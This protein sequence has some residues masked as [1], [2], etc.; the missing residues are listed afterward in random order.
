MEKNPE[1]LQG[2]ILKVAYEL[3]DRLGKR[4]CL[5]KGR[6]ERLRPECYHAH[7]I[8]FLT[9]EK[10][11]KMMYKIGLGILAVLLSGMLYQQVATAID[12]FLYPP[13][14][15]LVKVKEGRFHLH[16][17]GEGECTVILDAGLGGN[18]LG[19]SLV[20]P[21]VSKYARVCSFDRAGYGWSKPLFTKRTSNNI[22]DEL[23]A[24]LQQ[25]NIPGPYI[26][27]GH[28]F[29]GCNMLM[30]AHKYPADVKGVVLVDSVHEELLKRLPFEQ[31]SLFQRCL[32]HPQFEWLLSL[33][34]YKRARGHSQEIRQMMAPL[35]Q[36]SA[37]LAL[38]NKTQYA[39]AV[40]REMQAFEESLQ[41]LK[42]VHL[43]DKPLIVI[44]AGLMANH[45]EGLIWKEL[46]QSLLTKSSNAKQIIAEQSDHMINHHQPEIIIEAILELVAHK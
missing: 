12:G 9:R 26:L 34:G 46:Q 29:G 22:A 33:I 24:C 7:P 31:K 11:T 6:L 32:S 45:E 40:A 2:H 27:V 1:A 42:S 30:F 19:W 18:L 10:K 8:N 14:G 37:Y 23:S 41:E 5:L 13:L 20:Q 16:T 35:P 43:Q 44:T 38:M 28:S 39:R 21:E 25:A 36:K 3:Q 17:T 4:I 15:K